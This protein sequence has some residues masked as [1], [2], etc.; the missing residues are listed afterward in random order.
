[1]LRTALEFLAEELK[2]HIQA[3]D[4][5]FQNEISV[6]VSSLM[7]PD[8]TFAIGA[9]QNDIT[10]KLVATLVNIEEDRIAESQEY[11]QRINDRI[12]YQ[13][14]PLNINLYVLFSALADNYFSELRLLSY[15][16]IFFQGN[17]VFDAE[18]YPHINNKVEAEKPWQRIDKLVATLHPLSFEQQNN[19]WAALGAK[20]MPSV[21]YKIRTVTFTDLEPKMEAPPIKEIFISTS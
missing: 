16:L 15:V 1:M 14:P 2:S 4:P 20:Y 19:L 8:G 7:K 10:F 18:R 6:V 21:L 3:K 13:N 5:V 17:T 9:A 11:F 12:R